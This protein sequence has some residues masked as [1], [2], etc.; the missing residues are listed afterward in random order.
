MIVVHPSAVL[1]LLERAP[2][3]EALAAKISEAD[4]LVLSPVAAMDVLM[5][6][7]VAYADPGPIVTAFLRQSRIGLRPVDS[8]QAYWARHGFLNFGRE[9]WSLADCFTYGAAKALDAPLLCASD[10]FAKSDLKPA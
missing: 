5:T 2:G 4:E 6:L 7:S 1:A 9:R 3:F 10:L 8:N